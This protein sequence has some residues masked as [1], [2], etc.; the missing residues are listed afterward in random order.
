V[1]N[2][3]IS[4]LAADTGETVRA[5]QHW[6][7]LGVLVAE[8]ATEK[9]G[10]GYHREFKDDERKWALLASSLNTLRV[11]LTDIAKYLRALR[12]YYRVENYG[13]ADDMRNAL[14]RFNAS[15]MSRALNS[16]LDVFVMLCLQTDT[17][18]LEI[19]MKLFEP[20]HDVSV[21]T[22]TIKQQMLFSRENPQSYFLNL[23]QI[24]APLRKST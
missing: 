9:K 2:V 22:K 13:A 21:H 15:P 1:A 14:R 8:P 12:D 5:L 23:S 24:W 4:I 17:N 7:D 18:G 6:C 20:I 11:P 19:K 10:R 16:D 3:S